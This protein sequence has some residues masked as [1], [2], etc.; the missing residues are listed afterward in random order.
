MKKTTQHN[1]IAKRIFD[2]LRHNVVLYKNQQQSPTDNYRQ[3][4]SHY[5]LS[6]LINN[7]TNMKLPQMQQFIEWNINLKHMQEMQR[8]IKDKQFHKTYNTN[9]TAINKPFKPNHISPLAQTLARKNECSMKTDPNY[10]ANKYTSYSTEF[11]NT[12]SECDQNATWYSIKSVCD[13]CKQTAILRSTLHKIFN[14]TAT[15]TKRDNIINSL[16]T[17]LKHYYTMQLQ[18]C[19]MLTLVIAK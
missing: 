18:T 17:E 10:I 19:A 15:K 3:V 14:C 16:L 1:S 8:F 4:L 9:D 6:V 12:I 5:N 7:N 13:H 11:I 2:F